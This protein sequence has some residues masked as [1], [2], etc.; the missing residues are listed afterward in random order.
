MVKSPSKAESVAAAKVAAAES[1]AQLAAAQQAPD[2]AAQSA[3]A[4]VRLVAV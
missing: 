4:R 3:E 2:P 1:S